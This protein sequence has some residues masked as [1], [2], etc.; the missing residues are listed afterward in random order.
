M[1]NLW[2]CKFSIGIFAVFIGLTVFTQSSSGA[3]E[4]GYEVVYALGKS[5]V[6]PLLNSPAIADLNGKTLCAS[7][8]TFEGDEALPAL[9]NL[10]KERYPGI[11]YVSNKEIPD[12]VNTRAQMKEF[13]ELLRQKG[14]DAVIS[15]VG[16]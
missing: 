9:V 13:Q 12:D 14:C 16:C 10:L 4:G 3:Q 7:G 5:A 11:Q 8:H 15:G 2:I 6:K 1:R